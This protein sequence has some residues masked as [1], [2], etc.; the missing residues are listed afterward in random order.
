M[1]R[2]VPLP[3][4]VFVNPAAGRGS[5]GRKVPELREAF[6][7]RKYPIEIVESAS[8][9]E[10]QRGVQAAVR[11]GCAT[12]IAMGGDG[13]VQLLVR[14]VIG[15]D[16][17]VGVI[18]A[19]G[20]NDFAA[21]LGITK[22]VER[23]AEIIVRGKTR[24]VDLVR[25][26]NSNG[27]DAIYL[28]GGGM[29]IDAEAL[30]YANGSFVKWP[31]RLRYV[32]SAFA[33]LR[34]FRGVQVQVEFPESDLPTIAKLVLLAAVLN[35]PTFGG[36]LRLAPEAKLDDGQLEVVMIEMLRKRE[37]LALIPRLLLTGELK[38]KRVV[39]MRAAKIKLTA[40]NETDY[41]GDGE[42]LGKTPVEIEILH[43]ALRV[44]AP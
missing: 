14:E 31:G 19:G 26:R 3:A 10:L 18:P 34:E 28:G 22:N 44:L 2:T 40:E 39:R 15:R 8:A 1:E 11:E 7:R 41:Q 30:R 16:V 17:Q 38:T 33:A 27:L 43:R 24:W 21:A 37:V 5:A 29:G 4:T 32:A 13:T 12:L 23:A 36:G 42:L 9:G 25:V 6:A 20:G 35:T